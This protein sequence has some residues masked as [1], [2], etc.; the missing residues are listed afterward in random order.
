[1]ARRMEAENKLASEIARCGTRTVRWRNASTVHSVRET[2]RVRQR[3]HTRH[4]QRLRGRRYGMNACGVWGL[5]GFLRLIS[6]SG[7][8][9]HAFSIA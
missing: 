9:I 8:S 2:R 3:T 5:C 4:A 1:M 7:R 6:R